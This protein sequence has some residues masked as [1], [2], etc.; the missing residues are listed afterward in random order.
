MAV[1]PQLRSCKPKR[2]KRLPDID[3]AQNAKWVNNFEHCTEMSAISESL[4]G[5]ID[6]LALLGAFN[7]L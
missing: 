6:V 4:E 7:A 2:H 3:P 5:S 1:L